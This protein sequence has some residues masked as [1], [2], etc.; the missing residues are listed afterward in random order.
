M[1]RL[2]LGHG[3]DVN[4][5][6]LLDEPALKIAVLEGNLGM[7]TLLL[8]AGANMS[9]CSGGDAGNA[10]HAAAM[11]GHLE[12]VRL[13]LDR[14]ADPDAEDMDGRTAGYLQREL[15]LKKR[16]EVTQEILAMLQAASQ[17]KD[18]KQN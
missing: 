11:C 16:P 10:L 12:I 18:E 17:S 8:D 3:A 4:R 15:F 13:L 6:G 2:L 14:G 7:V 9:V 5:R 1:V